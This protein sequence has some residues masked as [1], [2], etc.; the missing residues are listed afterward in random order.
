MVINFFGCKD[1]PLIHTPFVQVIPK[2]FKLCHAVFCRISN[3]QMHLKISFLRPPVPNRQ[4]NTQKKRGTD[5]PLLRIEV[6]R[7]T[8]DRRNCKQ[9]TRYARTFTPSCCRLEISQVPIR[10][11]SINASLINMYGLVHR[12]TEDKN[13]KLVLIDKNIFDMGKKDG[14]YSFGA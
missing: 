4:L 3:M 13:R 5:I 2:W 12:Q 6:L 8:V 10:K 1:N 14:L 7:F 11:T 9:P